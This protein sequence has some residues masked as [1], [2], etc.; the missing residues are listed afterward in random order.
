MKDKDL[1]KLFEEKR[2][3]GCSNQRQ[4]PYSS[5]GREDNCGSHTW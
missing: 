4:S 1:L 2:M 5:E 3:D